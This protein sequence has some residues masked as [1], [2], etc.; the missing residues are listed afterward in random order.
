MKNGFIDSLYCFFPVFLLFLLFFRGK[1]QENSQNDP[2]YYIIS[3][4][5]SI[6]N[7]AHKVVSKAAE[8]YAAKI[9]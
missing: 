2:F 7:N 1:N 4:T 6:I 8:D 5:H 3:G 9:L